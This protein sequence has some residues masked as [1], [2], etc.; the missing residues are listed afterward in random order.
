MRH[1]LMLTAV[2]TLSACS[3]MPSSTQ[4]AQATLLPTSG[5]T[6][7]GKVSFRQSGDTL[8]LDVT[9]SGLTPGQHGFHVH[10]KGDCSA[11]DASSAGGHFNPDKHLHGSPDAQDHHLGDLGNVVA[12]ADGRVSTSLTIKGVRLDQLLGRSLIV[13]AGADDL[14]SQPAGNSGARIACGII[15]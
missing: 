13:H 1:A 7:T 15:S 8:L 11:P 6:T 2:A 14:K 4:T 10:E 5:Q 12:G 9:L 3:L